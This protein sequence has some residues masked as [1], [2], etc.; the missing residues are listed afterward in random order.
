MDIMWVSSDHQ[1]DKSV[2]VRIEQKYRQN[3]AEIEFPEKDENTSPKVAAFRQVL[4]DAEKRKE[5]VA[6]YSKILPSNETGPAGKKQFVEPK[7]PT[8]GTRI[9]RRI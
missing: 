4:R 6:I 5:D 8:K 3:M 2:I 1:E 9:D 7:S